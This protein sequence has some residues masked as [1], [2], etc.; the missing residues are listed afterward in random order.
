[1]VRI[2]L[3]AVSMI[4][5]LGC[6]SASKKMEGA[7][8]GNFRAR[9]LIKDTKAQKS[10]IVNLNF[11]V[12]RNQALRLDVSSPLN[13]HLA[14]FVVLPK[15]ITYFIVPEKTYYSGKL[16]DDAMAKLLPI[17]LNPSWLENILFR[18]AFETKDWSC[19][20]N[21]AGELASC[22]NLREQFNV[23]W[24]KGD[25]GRLR[26]DMKH[27]SGEIQMNLHVNAPKVEEGV[28]MAP[29]KAPQG[30]RQIKG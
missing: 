19:D 1:M 18:K 28:S 30:F 29:L 6:Q 17:P 11:N 22:M 2:F 7:S 5:M 20:Q 12:I 13:Q 15:S 27:P 21:K 16:K 14:S 10:F 23:S 4:S 24:T 25:K 26:I 8:E 3:V 9:A